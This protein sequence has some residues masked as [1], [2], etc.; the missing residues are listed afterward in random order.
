[1]ILMPLGNNEHAEGG[2]GKKSELVKVCY[3]SAACA[4]SFNYFSLNPCII[5]GN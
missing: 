2:E 5:P 1:M 3:L 4:K